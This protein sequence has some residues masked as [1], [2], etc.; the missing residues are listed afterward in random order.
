MRLMS[1]TTLTPVDIGGGLPHL[2]AFLLAYNF[3]RPLKALKFKSPYDIILE[4]YKQKPALFHLNPNQKI[5]AP[6]T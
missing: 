4:K 1:V 2:M 5:M 3:Q 6:N